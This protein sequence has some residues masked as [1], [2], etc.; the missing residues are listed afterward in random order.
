[1]PQS[2]INQADCNDLLK[3]AVTEIRTARNVIAKQINSS[4]NSVYWNLGK[5][6]FEIEHHAGDTRRD[7]YTF[8]EIPFAL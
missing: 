6:L 1:M 2:N 5:L 8:C 3:L 4:T 7:D